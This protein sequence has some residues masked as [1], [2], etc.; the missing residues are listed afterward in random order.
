MTASRTDS[1][2]SLP[3]SSS[4]A[5][6]PPVLP[7]TAQHC[8]GEAVARTEQ[9]SP[10]S[11]PPAALGSPTQVGGLAQRTD[12]QPLPPGHSLDDQEAQE[13]TTT[14]PCSSQPPRS[15]SSAVV[16]D[17]ERTLASPAES[18]STSAP[19][20]K[21]HL[22]TLAALVKR[23][24]K[25]VPLEVRPLSSRSSSHLAL[26][27]MLRSS[28]ADQAASSCR[29]GQGEVLDELRPGRGP[30]RRAL[31]ARHSCASP[32]SPLSRS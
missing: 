10:T 24:R 8:A 29:F 16:D 6:M 17:D 20:V 28:P 30:T 4:S 23:R 27:L 22:A 31:P 32:P 15:S 7:H 5:L 26:M 19:P 18:A 3:L 11:S 12:Q 21:S 9:H 25:R 13:R 2:H 14:R 1:H